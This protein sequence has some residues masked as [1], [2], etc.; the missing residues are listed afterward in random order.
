MQIVKQ[1]FQR[2]VI[3]LTLFV[4]VILST[5]VLAGEQQPKL[6][7][8]EGKALLIVYRP[9]FVGGAY[10]TFLFDVVGDIAKPLAWIRRAKKT[11]IQVEPGEHVFM[12][13][14]INLDFMKA[15]LEANKTYYAIVKPR[16]MSGFPIFPIKAAERTTPEFAKWN[17]AKLVGPNLDDAIDY[18]E[19]MTKELEED[20]ESFDQW[21]RNKWKQW[22]TKTKEEKQNLTLQPSDGE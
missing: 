6:K 11:A 15:H 20:P 9:S 13:A 7:P 5:T 18:A 8:D 3:L 22:N 19:M 14:S 1:Q 21:R 4:T 16:Y 17:E 12:I 2:V 10:Q